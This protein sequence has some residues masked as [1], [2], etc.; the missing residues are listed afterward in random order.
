M[1]CGWALALFASPV[2]AALPMGCIEAT[3]AKATIADEIIVGANDLV[4]VA[5]DGANVPEAMVPSLDAI[6]RMAAIACTGTHI[7]D[8]RVLTAAH[9]LVADSWDDCANTSIEWGIRGDGRAGMVGRC[10]RILFAELTEDRDIAV[11]EVDEA[12]A[13]ALHPDLCRAHGPGDGVFLFS[14]PE[15]RPL[16]WSGRCV[17]EPLSVL[18]LG[19]DRIGSGCDTEPGSSGAA[20]L[21]EETLEVVAVHNGGAGEL[22]DA[23]LLFV[24]SDLFAPEGFTCACP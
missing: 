17:L 1:R 12:P 18:A 15:R 2:V 19:R 3:D 16:E 11:F 14:H 13:V 20:L 9:C 10:Q 21:D 5:A 8:H 23:T 6:G 4:A 24:M 7:G 22:N